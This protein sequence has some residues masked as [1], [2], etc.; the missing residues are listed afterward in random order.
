MWVCVLT[1]PFPPLS[2]IFCRLH[3]HVH[4]GAF[5]WGGE[6]LSGACLPLLDLVFP[7]FSSCFF[8]LHICLK[9]SW[10]SQ[11]ACPAGLCRWARS[12]WGEPSLLALK[13]FLTWWKP[14]VFYVSWSGRLV[15]YVEGAL[16][17]TL[18]PGWG[19][20]LHKP[21]TGSLPLSLQLMSGVRISRGIRV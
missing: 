19:P 4:W 13:S 10:L 9:G 6:G 11:P 5:L 15:N 12:A 18:S 2:G 16:G 20:G 17:S 8:F 21:A 14:F 7:F 3:S 1:W